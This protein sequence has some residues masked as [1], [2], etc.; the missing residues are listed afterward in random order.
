MSDAPDRLLRLPQVLRLVPM[1]RSTL[2]ERI[3][4]GEFPAPAQ[5]GSSRC[6]AWSERRVQGYIAERLSAGDDGQAA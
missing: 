5:L 1:S 2:Y 6:V 4:A 3:R